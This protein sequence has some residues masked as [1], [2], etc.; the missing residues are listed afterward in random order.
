MRFADWLL[1]QL[2]KENWTQVKLAKE[3]G[4][5]KQ[6]ITNY[7]N[8]RTPDKYAIERIAIAFR[9]KPEEV[10]RVAMGKP[11]N[12]DADPWVDDMSHKL[13]LLSPGLRGVAERFINSMLEG[14]QTN[15]PKAK[16]KTKQRS[17]T[18]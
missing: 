2:A 16:S 7:V 10:Y 17:S 4:L 6:A 1:A 13:S 15:Q 3:S 5:S 12:P 9:L 8:G 18:L 14:E 11:A